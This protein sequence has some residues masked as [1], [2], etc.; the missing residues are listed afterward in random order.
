M[1][2]GTERLLQDNLIF[3]VI[4]FCVHTRY[5]YVMINALR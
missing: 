3:G 4:P 1:S 2:G 5:K